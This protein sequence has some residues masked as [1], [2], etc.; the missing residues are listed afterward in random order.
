MKT[1]RQFFLL[2]TLA[3]VKQQI[4]AGG[5]SYSESTTNLPVT[6]SL[7]ELQAVADQVLADVENALAEVVSSQTAVIDAG[8]AVI[9]NLLV[10]ATAE[11]EAI[12]NEAL[13]SL[14]LFKSKLTQPAGPRRKRQ[15]LAICESLDN[16]IVKCE[17]QLDRIQSQ[18]EGISFIPH[19][20]FSKCFPTE[21]LK[22]ADFFFFLSWKPRTASSLAQCSSLNLTPR[23]F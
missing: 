1:L 5:P 23:Q 14:E 21:Y 8:I 22:I 20:M 18:I 10:N 15:T 2:A 6:K 4:D 19:C 17:D 7:E 13:A 11:E 9:R 3:M 12:I 16:L